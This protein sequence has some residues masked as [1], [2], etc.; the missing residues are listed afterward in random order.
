MN[1]SREEISHIVQKE[2]RYMIN[3]VPEV[4]HELIG[5][6]AQTFAMRSDLQIILSHLDAQGER[7]EALREDFNRQFADHTQ[8]MDAFAQRMDHF[9]EVQAEH[10]KR[11]DHFA[12]VQVE[13]SKRMD[14]FAEVQVEH[15]KRMDHFA[16]V[17]AEHSQ[18]MDAFAQRMDHFAEVQAEHSQRMDELREDFNRGFAHLSSRIDRLDESVSA[19]NMS[20]SAMGARWGMM[21]ESAFREGLIGVLKETGWHVKNY[22]KMD[23]RGIVFAEPDQVEIDV[24]IHNG[25]H[26][27]IEIKSSV[28]R[29]DVEHFRRK[30]IFYEQEEDVKVE[31]TLIIS[32]MFGPRARELAQAKGMET[33]TSAYDVPGP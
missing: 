25:A 30:V 27:L 33:Y 6:M 24:V 3:N 13:H 16:E 7:S 14:H 12:E 20:V 8:R 31:R 9:A 26:S 19:L 4:Q 22:W 2:L 1:T 5:V 10:S 17:Q 18:R 29:G 28:S 23:T 15:S 21:S 32:P 11:M